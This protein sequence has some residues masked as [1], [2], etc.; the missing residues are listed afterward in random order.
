MI[1]D[2]ILQNVILTKAVVGR[3]TGNV[4]LF[5][6]TTRHLHSP[7]ILKSDPSF[8]PVQ[9]P[10][11]ALDQFTPLENVPKVKLVKIDVEGYELDVLAGMERL[12][13]L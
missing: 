3:E 6:P 1:N 10:V 5:L 7:S 11:I 13:Y 12:S 9:V 2:S 4:S 8:V